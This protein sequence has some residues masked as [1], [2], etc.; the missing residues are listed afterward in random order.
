[1]RGS[2]EVAQSISEISDLLKK[3]PKCIDFTFGFPFAC[4]SFDDTD[5]MFEVIATFENAPQQIVRFHIDAIRD[6][7]SNYSKFFNQIWPMFDHPDEGLWK[8]SCCMYNSQKYFPK[9][10]PGWFMKRRGKIFRE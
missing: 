6:L 3:L 1:M 10:L 2:F 4:A 7:L 8:L 5:Y 9:G